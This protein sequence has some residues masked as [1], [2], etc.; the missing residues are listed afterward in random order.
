MNTLDA[1][2]NQYGRRVLRGMLLGER[3][4][5]PSADLE[6]FRK[7]GTAHLLAVSGLHVGALAGSAWW[8]ATTFFALIR[9]RRGQVYACMVTL[10]LVWIFVGVTAYPISAVR[11]GA[12]ISLYLLSKANGSSDAT[13]SSTGGHRLLHSALRGHSDRQFGLSILVSDRRRLAYHPCTCVAHEGTVEY[14]Y[15]SELCCVAN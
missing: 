14:Q 11:A 10:G 7:T 1:G 3:T 5:V 8:L 6:A 12:M 13:A 15:R 9:L 2:K 4:T